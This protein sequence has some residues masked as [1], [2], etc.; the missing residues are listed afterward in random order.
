M[1]SNKN[2]RTEDNAV[3]AQSGFF[4]PWGRLDSEN[5]NKAWRFCSN[6]VGPNEDML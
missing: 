2:H 6:L 5:A 4:Q 3:V 1:K